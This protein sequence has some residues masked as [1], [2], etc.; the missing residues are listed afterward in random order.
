MN[1]PRKREHSI[2]CETTEALFQDR[3]EILPPAP[4]HG[5]TMPFTGT[6]AKS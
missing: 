3:Y 4:R 1:Q 5:F 2:P 6:I